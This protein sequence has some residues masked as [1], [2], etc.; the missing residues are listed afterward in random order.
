MIIAGYTLGFIGI[1]LAAVLTVFYWCTDRQELLRLWGIIPAEAPVVAPSVTSAYNA[2]VVTV[3]AALLQELDRDE[4]E[5][6]AQ[7]TATL[8]NNTTLQFRFADPNVVFDW[9]R[10]EVI[11]AF[12]DDI[13][14][15][16]NRPSSH[17]Y[18]LAVCKGECSHGA[19]R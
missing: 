7:A 15:R 14:R 16:A 12:D 6:T 2:E 3:P 8:G 4:D 19:K 17:H 13:Q 9:A 10:D 11:A 1:V 5:I 18:P